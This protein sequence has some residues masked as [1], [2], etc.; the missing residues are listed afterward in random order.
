MYVDQVNVENDILFNE[1][2]FFFRRIVGGIVDNL[3]TGG[4]WGLKSV[5]F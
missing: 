4:A 5:G 1:K 2:G 3:L